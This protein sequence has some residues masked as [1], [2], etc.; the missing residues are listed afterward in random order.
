MCMYLQNLS[1]LSCGICA[2]KCI[3][4]FLKEILLSV[5]IE[6]HALKTY[7]VKVIWILVDRLSNIHSYFMAWPLAMNFGLY[8]KR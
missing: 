4:E 2:V 8:S 1:K 5:S 3:M 7:A 6:L